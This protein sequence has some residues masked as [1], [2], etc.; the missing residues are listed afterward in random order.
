MCSNGL[1]FFADFLIYAKL[2]ENCTKRT[3]LGRKKKNLC[4]T[5]VYPVKTLINI[6]EHHH[7][8]LALLAFEAWPVELFCSLRH[9][10]LIQQ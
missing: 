5:T 1:E 10:D 9:M 3:V 7:S 2:A 4:H 6:S 8:A